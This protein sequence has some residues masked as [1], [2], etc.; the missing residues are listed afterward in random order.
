VV[1]GEYQAGLRSAAAARIA[2]NGRR[3]YLTAI[4]ALV[5]FDAR[6]RLGEVRCP[7]LVVAGE[8]DTTIPMAAKEALAHGIPAARLVV[9]PD[10]GHVTPW[11]QA[12][13]FNRIVRDFLAGG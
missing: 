8:R 9:V 5:R 6:R 4:A 10:S 13:A 3:A 7:T 2:G 11:D 12:G 1:R